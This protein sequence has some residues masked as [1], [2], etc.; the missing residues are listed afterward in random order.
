MCNIR[1]SSLLHAPRLSTGWAD[2]VISLLDPDIRQ[3]EPVPTHIQLGVSEDNHRISFFDDVEDP[4]QIGGVI[5]PTFEQI[6][7]IFLFTRNDARVLVHCHA[8]ICRSPAMAIGLL[9]ARGVNPREATRSIFMQDLIDGEGSCMQPNELILS[10]IDRHL[11][12][13]RRLGE[14]G[15]NSL[16]GIVREEMMR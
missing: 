1:V 12:L 9:I 4:T 5:P 14:A 10:H 8:G 2:Q 7:D 15:N 6:R 13:S 3:R 16:V 11:G